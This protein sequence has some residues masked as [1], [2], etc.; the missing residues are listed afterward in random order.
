MNEVIKRLFDR[1]ST[2]VFTDQEIS[3]E[4]KRLIIEDI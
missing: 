4:A 2:R 1:K 3:L